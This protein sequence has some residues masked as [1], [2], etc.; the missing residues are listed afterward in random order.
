MTR[1]R[2]KQ[3]QS[4]QDRLAAWAELVRKRAAQ[5]APGPERDAIL[6]KLAQARTAVQMDASLS[7]PELPT[8]R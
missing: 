3:N 4:L 1:R 2:L 6:K 8:S 7:S 5:L